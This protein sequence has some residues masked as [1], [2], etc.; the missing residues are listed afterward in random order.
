MTQ[1]TQKEPLRVMFC[2]GVT[3][4]FFDLPPNRLKAVWEAYVAMINELKN[5]P[6]V[7][8]LGT[9]DDDRVM[10]GTSYAWPWTSYILA[11]VPDYETSVAGC[12]LFR[13]IKVSDDEFLWKYGRIEARIGRPFIL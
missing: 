5:L 8:I 10:V 3:Q 11:D 9:M 2:I 13:T 12:N 7:K 6:G 4:N 1:T